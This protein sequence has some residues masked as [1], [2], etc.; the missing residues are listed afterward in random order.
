MNEVEYLYHGSPYLFDIIRPQK[1][2]GENLNCSL[3]AIYAGENFDDVI[4]FAL[5]IRWYPDDPSGKRS[6]ACQNGIVKIMQ[7]TLNPN[8]F[9]YVYKIKATH[10]EKI[11]H[12]QWVSYQEIIPE[13]RIEIRVKDYWERVTFSE[14]AKAATAAL[15]GMANL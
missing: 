12:W 13:E 15:Y 6:F 2:R 11:D 14:E 7:G 3:Y 5:P 4:P 8:G 10:F 1:A 9:G